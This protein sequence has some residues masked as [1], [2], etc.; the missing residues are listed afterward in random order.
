MAKFCQLAD[1]YMEGRP[2]LVNPATIR[3]AHEGADDGTTRLVFDEAH[4]VTVQGDLKTV[5]KNLA[6]ADRT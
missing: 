3:I 4:S 1:V 6:D 2:I 5:W